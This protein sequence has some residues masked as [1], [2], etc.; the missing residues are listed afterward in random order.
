MLCYCLLE[1][2][3]A[4][5][6]LGGGVWFVNSTPKN[7]SGKRFSIVFKNLIKRSKLYKQ[8]IYKNIYI[9]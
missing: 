2:V 4:Q 7:K 1:N 8:L 9:L 5:K 6:C 3:L